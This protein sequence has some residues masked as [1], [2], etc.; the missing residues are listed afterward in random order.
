MQSHGSNIEAM[1]FLVENKV[2]SLFALD[3]GDRIEAAVKT[4]EREVCLIIV[5]IHP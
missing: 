4:A 5:L 1:P 3:P 2:E